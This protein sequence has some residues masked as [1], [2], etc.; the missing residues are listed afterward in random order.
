M[1]NLAIS[2]AAAGRTDAALKLFEETLQQTKTKLGAD[3]S[4]TLRIMMNLANFYSNFGRTQEALRLYE[5]TFQLQKAKLG[6]DHPETVMGMNNLAHTYV[7]AG[8]TAQ[9]R[10]TLRETLKL[11]ERRVKA[12]PGNSLEQSHLA[13]THGQ[14]GEAEQTRFDFAAAVQA[15]AASVEMFDKL[16]QAG[17][18]KD[19]FHRGG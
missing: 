12:E 17:A 19:A 7:A 1:A 2:Y 4:D 6:A 3:H 9:A 10:A 15:Y 13:W 8:N 5:E 18:L 14:M 11:R 16:D